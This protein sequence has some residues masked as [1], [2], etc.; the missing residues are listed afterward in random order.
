MTCSKEVQE[1]KDYF[2]TQERKWTIDLLRGLL[3]NKDSYGYYMACPCR[4]ASGQREAGQDIICPCE[5]RAADV[6]EF[7]AC[8][9]QLYVPQEWNEDRLPHVLVSEQR[10]ADRY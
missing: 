2:F 1:H 8:Y 3:I 10:P 7:G 5:Y 9:C 6:D 4:L